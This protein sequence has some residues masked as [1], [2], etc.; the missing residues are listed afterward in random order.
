MKIRMID[1]RWR[2]S[3]AFLLA[4]LPLLTVVG[5]S[6]ADP[7]AGLAGSWAGGGWVAF[8]GGNKEK[9]RCHAHYAGSGGSYTVSATCA[10]VS[11]KATQT[12]NVHKVSGS[13]YK[14]SF[15]NSDYNVRGTIRVIVHGETQS[16]SLAGDGAS[17]QLSLS[18]R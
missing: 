9:A 16:V 14:G 18:R 8:A 15:F 12:A 3:G 13:S 7:A 2:C 6:E 4:A 10:T 17:A 1:R 5:P 11:G